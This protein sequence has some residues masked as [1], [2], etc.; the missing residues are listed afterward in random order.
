MDKKQKLIF[1]KLNFTHPKSHM[2][3]L[4][5]LYAVYE[6]DK[7]IE[8]TVQLAGCESTLNNMYIARVQN[9]VKNLN[10]AFVEIAPEIRCYLPL[11]ELNEIKQPLFTKKNSKKNIA[12][13]DELVVQVVKEAIKT[14]DAIVSTNISFAGEYLVLTSANHQIGISSKIPKDV[15]SRLRL[16]A[17]EMVPDIRQYGII[18][19]TNAAKATEN[20]IRIEFKRLKNE[21]DTLISTAHTR[22]LYTCLRK[23]QPLYL[24]MLQNIDKNKL[25]EV[26]TDDPEIYEQ[27]LKETLH[28]E[29]QEYSLRYYQD[30]L[31]T[32]AKL[33]RVQEQIEAAIKE[34]VWLKSGANI[35]I[36][37]T[38]ALTVIDVNSGK[39][40]VGKDRLLYHYKINIEAAAEIA[41][42]LRLR[43]ISGIILVD[44]IDLH[45]REQSAKLL[46]EFRKFLK[47][48]SIPVQLVDMTKLGLVELTRKKQKKSLAEQL[49][50][51][52]VP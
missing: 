32:L 36:Q 2:S 45:D 13:G 17:Q 15:A 42:Q 35:I 46:E 4:Y 44:F 34:R 33:Y 1:T 30:K 28:Q 9:I 16:F 31:L 24:K 5:D 26:L 10:A 50:V 47:Q 3:V 18:F 29:N 11:D 6:D 21:Y 52:A 41:R 39:N 38:E 51:H 40:I 23:E 43:N 7:M 27:L 19:R 8:V 14:K 20:H 37:P 49:S 22:T 25:D 12:V 48:D